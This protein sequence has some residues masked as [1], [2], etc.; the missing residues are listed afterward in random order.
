M[1]QSRIV[2]LES[3]LEHTESAH[4]VEVLKLQS[5]NSAKQLGDA[6]QTLE[7][8]SPVAAQPGDHAGGMSRKQISAEQELHSNQETQTELQDTRRKLREAVERAVECQKRATDADAKLASVQASHAQEIAKLAVKVEAAEAKEQQS[9]EEAAK[10][11]YRAETATS[12]FRS[13][14]DA[15]KPA[16][17]EEPP[18]AAEVANFEEKVLALQSEVKAM[19]DEHA[20]DLE[21]LNA[22]WEETL[23]ESEKLL[24][25]EKT[26]SVE[27]R[28]EV[29]QLL[30][31]QDKQHRELAVA[32]DEN[33][34][35]KAKDTQSRSQM[36]AQEEREALVR[37]QLSTLREEQREATKQL[38]EEM[39][40][41]KNGHSKQ[42]Q[43]NE[44]RL[45]LAAAAS[46]EQISAL[47]QSHTEALAA[48]QEEL[49]Q[50]KD[51]QDRERA[52]AAGV[53]SAELQRL[54]VELERRASQSSELN[55]LLETQQ[56]AALA[57]AATASDEAE[58]QEQRLA[59]KLRDHIRRS[60]EGAKVAAE[61][62][63]AQQNELHTKLRHAEA[64]AREVK[65]ETEDMQQRVAVLEQQLGESNDRATHAT[66]KLVNAESMVATQQAEM[67]QGQELA[68]EL[69]EKTQALAAVLVAKQNEL[70]AAKDGEKLRTGTAA[71][72]AEAEELT[73]ENLQRAHTEFENLKKSNAKELVTMAQHHA[74]TLMD[75]QQ[76]S[77]ASIAEMQ[78]LL[79]AQE[80]ATAA[81]EACV[82]QLKAEAS[83]VDADHAS[84]V[85][86]QTLVH[87]EEVASLQAEAAAAKLQKEARL[88]GLAQ[89]LEEALAAH[90]EA[91]AAAAS[92]MTA[93]LEGHTT[94]VPSLNAQ[95]SAATTEIARLGESRAP[96]ERVHEAESQ[97]LATS[98]A[99]AEAEL[100]EVQAGQAHVQQEQ[101]Q[102]GGGSAAILRGLMANQQPNTVAGSETNAVAAALAAVR[103]ENQRL[104]AELSQATEAALS[105]HE[106]AEQL[107]AALSE[108]EA[109]RDT[110]HRA[111]EYV[112]QHEFTPVSDEQQDDQ[113]EESE[114]ELIVQK[115]SSECP[116]EQN[117]RETLLP[118]AHATVAQPLLELQDAL[119]RER[120][121]A[122]AM[123]EAH[124]VDLAN[125]RSEVEA[126]ERALVKEHTANIEIVNARWKAQCEALRQA[127]DEE[128]SRQAEQVELA[129]NQR[130]AL[131]LAQAQSRHL[132][133]SHASAEVAL[134]EARSLAATEIAELHESNK[135]AKAEFVRSMSRQDM[136]AQ[137]QVARMS[138]EVDAK[139][140]TVAELGAA[141][142]REAVS[143]SVQAQKE[144]QAQVEAQANFLASEL[145]QAR[146]TEQGLA[147]TLDAV[148][149]EHS[150]AKQAAGAHEAEANEARED[151]YLQRTAH[152]EHL[153]TIVRHHE[154]SL[155]ALESE[156][157]SSQQAHAEEASRR[158][159]GQAQRSE[160]ATKYQVAAAAWNTER[161]GMLAE[162]TEL[163]Q[164]E[165]EVQHELAML[166][167]TAED[168]TDLQLALTQ[169]LEEQH[170]L[171]EEIMAG[172]DAQI[173][174]VD[175]LRDQIESQ[176]Q[177]GCPDPVPEDSPD[178]DDSTLDEDYM[179]RD[180][181]AA[182][183]SLAEF[184]TS[185]R[186]E[187]ARMTADQARELAATR[188]QHSVEI[189]NL[190]ATAD[191]LRRELTALQSSHMAAT[192]EAAAQAEQLTTIRQSLTDEHEAALALHQ[193]TFMSRLSQAVE[194]AEQTVTHQLQQ[195]TDATEAAA[196]Q[197]REEMKALK[198][199]HDTTVKNL[200]DK[201]ES[202]RAD[203]DATI[204]AIGANESERVRQLQA[205]LDDAEARHQQVLRCANPLVV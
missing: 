112:Q 172:H 30:K 78:E 169:Q 117:K 95:C 134:A 111:Q 186:D 88:T 160:D 43:E 29:A 130:A 38:T 85:A 174:E 131:K 71:A 107:Q 68:L 86:S 8:E 161:A 192:T 73:C 60:V 136:L 109:M 105:S 27:L 12:T 61:A 72:I 202:E 83:T 11:Y 80:N 45:K 114:E 31:V 10:Q 120:K 84:T 166:R 179:R 63:E 17:P 137:Q 67:V 18:A 110:E 76:T 176:Q 163:K 127:R 69:E 90:Q 189:E 35:L 28:Q 36:L 33:R 177:Q 59:A 13:E 201:L 138:K 173:D 178:T 49:A 26:R 65:V 195:A 168:V 56:A 118:T 197:H 153:Q 2:E 50:W 181:D 1:L 167:L 129:E 182:Q 4:D 54:S 135:V 47:R 99:Q 196:V 123:A 52:Q 14:P 64:A 101:T 113:Q 132:D 74:T 82:K 146:D 46:T 126:N 42:L 142:L 147:A 145:A 180:L 24:R 96:A 150:E 41:L 102:R 70:D 6:V 203:Y 58:M 106:R 151:M 19:Q 154:A 183:A 171:N 75:V 48:Q 139:V 119:A 149:T 122:E 89:E 184:K 121:S 5:S 165:L 93:T 162:L 133:A 141:K 144:S 124:A 23:N 158:S 100:A 7:H 159:R 40:E 66:Q 199:Q 128:A 37:K 15:G 53:L 44:Q 187:T 175:A 190:N 140:A 81:A 20:V 94:E 51:S 125:I 148:R 198:V 116:H 39:V 156:C 204:K 34:V 205:A 21:D 103:A 77:T 32:R 79:S 188:H 200:I 57:A 16:G 170:A 193:E 97:A 143:R 91:S 108:A 157:E 98:L 62:A 194:S 185:A 155:L 9:R 104:G 152:Q 87:E 191:T 92:Q 3:Q 25:A 164:S 55:E 22:R 115:L